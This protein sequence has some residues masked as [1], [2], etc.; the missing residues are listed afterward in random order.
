MTDFSALEAEAQKIINTAV[1]A[2]A[3]TD[4]V[5]LD[6]ANAKIAELQAQLPKPTP[7]VVTSKKVTLGTNLGD[8][9][10]W[11]DHFKKFPALTWARCYNIGQVAA[12]RAGGA[13]H[14]LLSMSSSAFYPDG[15]KATIDRIVAAAVKF[16]QDAALVAGD[17]FTYIH[18][19]N[20]PNKNLVRFEAS[21]YGW[22]TAFRAIK[23][24]VQKV[25]PGLLVGVVPTAY[26]V[27]TGQCDPFWLKDGE[28]DFYS[29]DAYAGL[30]GGNAAASFKSVI[31]PVVAKIRTHYPKVRI[32]F[33]EMNTTD[34]TLSAK[35]FAQAAIDAPVVTGQDTTIFLFQDHDALKASDFTAYVPALKFAGFVA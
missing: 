11:D 34:V 10:K 9:G 28:Q 27:I 7:V 8:T 15:T 1:A 32:D 5:S 30:N 6:A 21:G 29:P 23:A 20:T 22:T 3:A 16:V 4:K 17:K 26:G 35:W 33:P 25:I 19:F 12:A 13:K 31:T 18:E 2:Q 24:A 14:V